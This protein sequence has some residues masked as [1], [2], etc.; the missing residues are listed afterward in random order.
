MTQIQLQG[1]PQSTGEI[2]DQKDFTFWGRLCEIL[3]DFKTL[4]NKYSHPS[5]HILSMF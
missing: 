5:D 1:I 3:R 2:V 4:T